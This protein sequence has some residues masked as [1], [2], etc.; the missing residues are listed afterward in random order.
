[1][2]CCC[3]FLMH[4]NNDPSGKVVQLTATSNI[5]CNNVDLLVKVPRL[6]TKYSIHKLEACSHVVVHQMWTQRG[7]KSCNIILEGSS[8]VIICSTRSFYMS[9]INCGIKTN[10]LRYTR[11]YIEIVKAKILFGQR[12]WGIDSWF[13]YRVESWAAIDASYSTPCQH[14]NS[15]WVWCMG[16]VP[17]PNP[18]LSHIEQDI[19]NMWTCLIE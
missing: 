13:S 14:Y 10:I 6:S 8:L 3:A 18:T 12:L 15:S 9:F 5:G 2:L 7:A 4:Q 1:M 16:Q 19:D 17:R 11:L